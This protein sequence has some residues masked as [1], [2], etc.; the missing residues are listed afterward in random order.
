HGLPGS[1]ASQ[2]K[3]YVT[4]TAH[5]WLEMPL[6]ALL[7][8]GRQ[9][10]VTSSA[11]LRLNYWLCI[12]PML[13]SMDVA[14]IQHALVVDAE[15]TWPSHRQHLVSGN[16]YLKAY[17]EF[18]FGTE[19]GESAGPIE[20]RAAEAYLSQIVQ[21][22]WLK[23]AVEHC[24]RLRPYNMGLLYWQANDIWPTVSWSP[25][26]YSGRPKVAMTMAQSF[27]DLNE[28]TMFLNYS[29]SPP[30][31]CGQ[32]FA[33]SREV[34]VFSLLKQREVSPTLML[35]AW[36][37]RC[38]HLD[39]VCGDG[40][41]VA[42]SSHRNYLILGSM[43]KFPPSSISEFARA[44]IRIQCGFIISEIVVPFVELECETVC[45][46][47]HFLLLPSQPVWVGEDAKVIGSL[48][49]AL[50]SYRGGNGKDFIVSS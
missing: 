11:A 27:Y 24:R 46:E 34:R 44:T 40:E 7:V 22:M 33:E 50:D 23:L 18:M 49:S 2:P 37:L 9:L 8:I 39:G 32:A 42:F 41:C 14:G 5:Y 36:E 25:I 20:L 1:R 45:E 13:F 21:G 28:P 26:E 16:A 47:N 29:D 35:S 4:S 17:V 30:R 6:S 38:T 15:E 19:N 3:E 48:W 10:V 31:F 12:R 43:A